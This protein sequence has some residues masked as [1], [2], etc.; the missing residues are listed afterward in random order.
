MAE[1]LRPSQVARMLN[2]NESTIRRWIASGHLIAIKTPGKQHR[3][4]AASVERLMK[5]PP[6]VE[7]EAEAVA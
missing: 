2:V 5:L 6:P 7:P 3:I 1:L 4:D